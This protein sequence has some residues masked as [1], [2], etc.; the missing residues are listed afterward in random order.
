[1]AVGL[2]VGEDPPINLNFI[3]K[4]YEI[5]PGDT[6]VTSGQDGIF[7]AGFLIGKVERVERGGGTTF[8]TIAIRPAVNFS[9]LSIVLVLLDPPPAEAAAIK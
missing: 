5:N 2:G 3:N 1:V 8:K 4:S 7:P 6:V 9:H